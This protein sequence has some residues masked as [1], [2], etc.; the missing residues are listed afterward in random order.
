[1]GLPCGEILVDVVFHSV[2]QLWV[3]HGALVPVSEFAPHTLTPR[4][5]P[6]VLVDGQHVVPATNNRLERR[7]RF[8]LPREHQ[9]LHRGARHVGIHID[10]LMIRALLPLAA[11]SVRIVS[12][13]EDVPQVR[14]DGCGEVAARDLLRND[15]LPKEPHHHCGLGH[16]RERAASLRAISR[17]MHLLVVRRPMAQLPHVSRAPC[18][19]LALFRDRHRVAHSDSYVNDLGHSEGLEQPRLCAV[20][21]IAVA[22]KAAEAASASPNMACICQEEAMGLMRG[23]GRDLD[24]LEFQD[25]CRDSLKIWLEVQAQLLPLVRA[26]CEDARLQPRENGQVVERVVCLGHP[27]EQVMLRQNIVA[28]CIE[29]L[30]RE[31]AELHNCS[32]RGQSG[33]CAVQAC[34]DGLEEDSELVL[35]DATGLVKVEEAED[36]ADLREELHLGRDHDCC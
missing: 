10:E 5:D 23:D 17:L 26:P 30:G 4:P 6:V 12:P 14:K 27:H 24:A 28:D 11:L 15:P 9:S 13:G 34:R 2:H 7:A 31:A 1:M 35:A 19:D 20:V 18:E 32:R 16:V 3:V 25:G 22:Q 36:Q 21:Q 8:Y 29:E 33:H